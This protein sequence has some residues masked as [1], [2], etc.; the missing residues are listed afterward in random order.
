MQ[1]LTFYEYPLRRKGLPEYLMI[2]LHG[3]GSNGEDL[4]SLAPDFAETIPNVQFI[5][6]D[7]PFR[8]EGGYT[9]FQW[10]S[11]LDRSTKYMLNGA[12]IAEPILESFINSQLER[13][14]LDDSKLI[15]CGFSQG[16]MMATYSALKR[17]HPCAAVLSFS[18]Y[19]IDDHEF[20]SNI[21]SR[22]ET[23]LCHGKQD[24]IVHFDTYL[25]SKAKLESLQV[26][27]TSHVS[28]SLGHGI[29]FSCINAAK[30]FLKNKLNQS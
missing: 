30:D 13:F 23:F 16:A 26:P 10:Y 8:F 9:G 14:Q 27:I 21:K 2:L 29:D 11:L 7:A 25:K 28:E 6:P 15:L 19:I 5:S 20:N 22:P 3:Y 1:N 18:G 12:N 4:I 24:K 17:A